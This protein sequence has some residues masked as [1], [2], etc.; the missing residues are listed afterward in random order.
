MNPIKC[1]KPL[2]PGEP[3]TVKPTDRPLSRATH[4]LYDKWGRFQD[5]TSEFYTTFKYS[6][7]SGIGKAHGVTRRDPT[8]ILR[9]DGTYYVWY[10]RRKTDKDRDHQNMPPFREQSWDT[11]VYDCD[12]AEIWY[13]TSRDG[14]NWTEQGVAVRHGPRESLRRSFGV[15]ARCADD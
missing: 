14:F 6:R 3:T 11:P 13:A 1:D 9:I 15:Y 2:L 7:I 12:L 4:R 10:T 5:S 8:T